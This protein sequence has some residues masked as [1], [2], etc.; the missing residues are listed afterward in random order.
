MYSS[1]WEILKPSL[2]YPHKIPQGPILSTGLFDAFLIKLAD[3]KTV[4]LLILQVH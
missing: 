4:R 1:L 2:A 3:E